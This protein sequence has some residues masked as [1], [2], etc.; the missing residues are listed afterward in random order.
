MNTLVD[1]SY[2]RNQWSLTLEGEFYAS[3]NKVSATNGE[4]RS[5]GYGLLNLYGQYAFRNAG[6][7]VSAGVENVLDKT[8][9]PHL[10][11]INRVARSD[12][13]VGARIPGDGINAFIQAEWAF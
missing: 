11:G 3:Q 1:L 13:A 10:N 12:V 9:R 5:A 4:Q 6:I 7:N 2:E 8:Y